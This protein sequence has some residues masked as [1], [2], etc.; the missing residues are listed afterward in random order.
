MSN[1]RYV[2]LLFIGVAATVFAYIALAVQPP[3][4]FDETPPP[5]SFHRP[6][7]Y[8][9]P[10]MDPRDIPLSVTWIGV[11]DLGAQCLYIAQAG[12]TFRM[13]AVWKADLER[14]DREPCP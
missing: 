13:Q 6:Q 1:Q 10:N 14:E 9:T 4:V 11:Q 3:N 8:L 2:E 7:V 12:D 5:A